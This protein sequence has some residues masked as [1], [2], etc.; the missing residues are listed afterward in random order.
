M[1]L[2]TANFEIGLH[3]KEPDGRQQGWFEHNEYGDECGGGLWFYRN[4]LVD[5]DGI[6]GYLPE[7]VL[8]VLQYTMGFNV[9]YM[10]PPKEEIK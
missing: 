9:D 10:R 5:Y 4:E 3:A 1:T 6:C 2:Y 7:E 8:D